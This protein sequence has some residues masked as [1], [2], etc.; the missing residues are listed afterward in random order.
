MKIHETF[1]RYFGRVAARGVFGL[2]QTALELLQHLETLQ[3][4]SNQTEADP[5]Q[6]R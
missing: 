1:G 3:M 6:V 4:E 2:G 5:G